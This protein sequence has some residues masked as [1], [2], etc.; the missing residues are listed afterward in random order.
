MAKAYEKAHKPDL[1]PHGPN[2]LSKSVESTYRSAVRLVTL[3]TTAK[4]TIASIVQFQ[5]VKLSRDD[6]TVQT[7]TNKIRNLLVFL[8]DAAPT[9]DSALLDRFLTS[10]PRDFSKR[11]TVPQSA[12]I[13]AQIVSYH[14]ESLDASTDPK[15]LLD[16]ANLKLVSNIGARVTRLLSLRSNGIQE[17]NS[18]T[19]RITFLSAK[20]RKPGDAPQQVDIAVYNDS[21]SPDRAIK[22]IREIL[23]QT[24]LLLGYIRQGAEATAANYI[25]HSS[26]SLKRLF[27]EAIIES[28]NFMKHKVK[29]EKVTA[30]AGRFTAQQIRYQALIRP[31][32]RD[33]MAQHADKSIRR[34]YECSELDMQKAAE[35]LTE[36][37]AN[38]RR[39]TKFHQTLLAEFPNP[40]KRTAP[41]KSY[42][43]RRKLVLLL[44]ITQHFSFIFL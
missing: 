5:R 15:K 28:P 8:N 2:K 7:A 34:I 24:P 4:V 19:L 30:N 20:S 40:S 42:S 37:W 26:T 10:A 1:W 23:G 32:V 9:V 39:Y 43:K 38:D 16:S 31:E 13:P 35:L 41:Q 25:P 18:S 12:S 22:T 6:V 11:R 44:F 21:M 36:F 29:I 14:C 17:I 33:A 3:I 27:H